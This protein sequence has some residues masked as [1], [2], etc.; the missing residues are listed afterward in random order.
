MSPKPPTADLNTTV[1]R[2]FAVAVP[3]EF[4]GRRRAVHRRVV[5]LGVE[6]ASAHLRV[7]GLNDSALWLRLAWLLSDG[8]R[9][10]EQLRERPDNHVRVVH[11]QA[12][13]SHAGELP[14][15]PSE[16][17][18]RLLDRLLDF[19][20][21]VQRNERLKSADD[22]VPDRSIRSCGARSCAGNL[23]KNSH[24]GEDQGGG[25]ADELFSGRDFDEGLSV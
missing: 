5:R 22:P 4:D 17:T 9:F 13:A 6:E 21:P 19:W 12:L 3:V 24:S 25:G 10:R 15:F 16:L 14:K 18:H 1:T 11:S 7:G 8:S 23:L 20:I 2:I